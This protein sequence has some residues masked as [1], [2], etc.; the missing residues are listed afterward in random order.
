MPYTIRPMTA[1]DLPSRAAVHCQAWEETYRGL[2][3]D[4]VLDSMTAQSVEAAVRA[5]PMDTL[6]TEG[7][8]GLVGFACFCP[9]ARAFTGRQ[10]T[11][12]IA[13]LYL[14]RPAQ[15]RGLGRRLM[16]AVLASL[17]HPEVVLY[18]LKDNTQ[19]IGFY[20][21]MGFSLTGRSIRQDVP[22]GT[23]TELEMLL[24]REEA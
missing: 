20:E 21:H 16:E 9:E 2:L 24:Q 22:G 12:E 6:V 23:M 10:R 17:P 13:A 8:E 19:A 18:V 7:P 1:V 4:A 3:P 5:A 14:L 15:G 11:S